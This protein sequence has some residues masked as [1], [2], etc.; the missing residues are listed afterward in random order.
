[1]NKEKKS[2]CFIDD[3]ENKKRRKKR[4]SI[5]FVDDED[6]E[7]VRFKKFL[8]NDFIIGAGKTIETALSDLPKEIREKPDLFV[9]DLY[10]PERRD[11]SQAEREE[12]HKARQIYMKEQD[13]YYG[14]LSQYGQGNKGGY[15]LADEIKRKES[16][17]KIGFVY[18]TRKGKLEDAQEAF[19]KGAL[20]VMKKPDPLPNDINRQDIFKAYDDAF[21]DNCE[22][23]VGE[24]VDS[25]KKLTF[26]WKYKRTIISS[27]IS[28][29][30]GAIIGFIFYLF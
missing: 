3:Q 5:C 21:D 30:T 13:R 10:F 19:R 28:F 20:K 25:I 18:F 4:K 23:I 6:H 11:L 24:L 2:T 12:L 17:K 1:M 9:F 14:L 27:I 7:I 26:R 29:V 15:K 8:E 16:L 22:V